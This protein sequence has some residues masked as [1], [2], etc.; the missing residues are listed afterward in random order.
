MLSKD[1]NE[2]LCR[3]GPGTPMG[4]LMRQYWIPALPSSEFPHPDCPPKRMRLL[5]E[6]IVM[7]RD[8]T[9]RVG[10]LEEACPH[11]GASLYFGRNEEGGIRCAY[12]GWK[13]DV[14]GACL[15]APSEQP[16][17]RQALCARIHA[18]AYACHE[19]NHMVWVYM[20]NQAA[21]PPFPAF[22]INLLPSEQVGLPKIMMEEANWL[23]NLEGDMDSAHLDFVHRRLAEDSP[24]PEIGLRGFWNPTGR[25]P[26]LDVVPT[27][28]GAYYSAMRVL[29]NG[30]EWHRVNQFI[31]PFHTMITIGDGTI[32]LRSFVPI[33]DEHAMLINQTG[34]PTLPFEGDITKV[35]DAFFQSED[36]IERTN[37]PRSYFMSKLNKRNDY[38]RDLRVQAETMFCGIPFIGNLQDRAMTELM[39]DEHERPIYDRSKEHLASSDAMIALVRRQLIAAAQRFRD[40]GTPPANRDNVELDKVRGASLRC[41]PGSDWKRECAE[42][43]QAEPGK[44]ASAQVGLII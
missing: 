11:R 3:V 34:H 28:Y 35:H 33:D 7:F 10:A 42:A 25:P 38:G 2:L 4:N 17:K 16:E 37:D 1:K 9:G 8:S 12:H 22:E 21:P 40:E 13:F 18:K 31:F 41:G 27:D 24:A 29:E 19:V 14:T 5:G 23:Q 6:N 36:F 44:P 15:D 26:I 43:L 20:G 30:D 32:G 39:F